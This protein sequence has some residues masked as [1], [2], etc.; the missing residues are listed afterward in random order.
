MISLQSALV[1]FFSGVLVTLSWVF[2]IDGQLSS[3]DKL[4]G[5]H[6]LPCLFATIAAIAVNLV[7]I[8]D[9]SGDRVIVKA[10]LFFWVT[11]QC[12]CIGAAIFILSVEYPVFDNYPGIAIMIQTILC[13][14]SAFLFFIGKKRTD[15]TSF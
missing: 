4:A 5:T 1:G 6:L 3:H 10:W 12:I 15:S 2:F 8:N 13:M 14:L 11:V 7:S 9:V